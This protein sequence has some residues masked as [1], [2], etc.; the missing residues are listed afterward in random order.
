MSDSANRL[1]IE[2][3]DFRSVVK[4]LVSFVDTQDF[5]PSAQSRQ[6]GGADDRIQ[7]RRITTAGIDRDSPDIFTHAFLPFC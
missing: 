3:A 2:L 7:P 6:H 1:S 4:S 5:P